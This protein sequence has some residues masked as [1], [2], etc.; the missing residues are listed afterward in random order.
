MI[1]DTDGSPYRD[2]LE[3]GQTWIKG[4]REKTLIHFDERNVWYKTK[5]DVKN[6]KM[7]RVKRNSFRAW[8]TS[9]ARLKGVKL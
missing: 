9:G 3:N 1:Y 2:F 4:N 5:D 6:G 7:T 8:I